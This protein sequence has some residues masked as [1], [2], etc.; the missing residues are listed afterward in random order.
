[1][2]VRHQDRYHRHCMLD[3][4]RRIAV[5]LALAASGLALAAC[6][7]AMKGQPTA[8]AIH[9]GSRVSNSDP[10]ASSVVLLYYGATCPSSAEPPRRRGT[11]SGVLINRR[12]VL[13]SAHCLEGAPTCVGIGPVADR[14]RREY[15]Y[16]V[17][18]GSCF[19][20]PG[21]TNPTRDKCADFGAAKLI[22][23]HDL[24]LVR[25]EQDVP[26][27]RALPMKFAEYGAG[28]PPEGL[29]VEIAGFGRTALAND[30]LSSELLVGRAGK[31]DTTRTAVVLGDARA[32]GAFALEGDSG[33]P[34]FV[35][36]ARP[37]MAPE[38]LGVISSGYTHPPT[39]A[40]PV[41]RG[42]AAG[43]AADIAADINYRWVQGIIADNKD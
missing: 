24:G 15:L 2:E 38:L 26:E 7:G 6:A 13:T 30:A 5:G 43:S 36:S 3:G 17:K 31:F 34:A 22:Y 28:S 32:R 39:F 21:A 25:L 1:M 14:H 40:A 23:G 41:W 35:R 27:H 37:S 42:A 18:K 10:L 33:G 19:I 20:H 11:C 8:G 29:Q 9:G 12:W 16:D 4:R